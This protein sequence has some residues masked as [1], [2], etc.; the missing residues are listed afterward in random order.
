MDINSCNEVN[1]EIG[2]K[3]KL[4]QFK[5]DATDLE[6]GTNDELEPPKTTQCNRLVVLTVER[7]WR[8]L[9]I[10]SWD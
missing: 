2:G 9:E 7:R 5:K 3:A 8:Q 10:E 4:Q 1:A 6:S